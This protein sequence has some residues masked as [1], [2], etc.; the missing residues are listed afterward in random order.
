MLNVRPKTRPIARATWALALIA[1]ALLCFSACGRGERRA[2]KHV[3]LFIGDGMS[4]ES[5]IA[6]SRYLYGKD[7]ALAWHSLP[8]E[9]YEATWD[10][11][12]YNLNA[13]AAGRPRYSAA[14]FD[15]SLGYDVRREGLRPYPEARSVGA[16]RPVA[17]PAT[18]SASAATAL[19][20]GVKTDSGN[21]AWGAGDPPEAGL[22]TIAE[23][24]R[25]AR[26]G[27]F[28]V[29]STV[30]FDHATPA[31]F[32]SHNASRGHYYTGYKGYAG[33]GIADEII[34]DSKP[35]VVIGAGHPSFDNPSFNP[36]TGYISE[37]LYR[38]LQ[39]S[40]DYVLAERKPGRDG[41][42][43]LDEAAGL[44]LARGKKLFGLFGGPDG[45]FVHPV[46]E[47]HPGA[48]LFSG[49]SSEDPSLEDATLAAL[50]VLAA[51]PHG[52]FLMVEQGDIDWAN[53]D[54]DFRRMITCVAD[55]DAA[56]RAAV[57]F[58]DK[59]GDD[60]DWTNTVL[61]VTADHATGGMR[62]N[63]AMP[64]GPGALPRQIARPAASVELA[65]RPGQAGNGRRHSFV[66]PPVPAG[67]SPFFYPDGEV[68]YST[69]GHTNELVT[70]AA[71]GR[72]A[73]VFVDYLG[74]WYPGPIIDNTQVNAVM[75][76]ALGLAPR[77]R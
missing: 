64:L 20:T 27:G 8:V 43:T 49:E 60:I 1:A 50:R 13:K 5:E 71:K 54:N 70:L 59:P 18:D 55:L 15:P 46:P 12:A 24:F 56:V 57:A 77:G 67:A 9:W 41:G 73:R 65:P 22:A 37:S 63:P 14:E 32:V 62:L 40:N 28:G 11:T 4:V 47:N 16:D 72:A 10:L 26:G 33:L 44:A 29:V 21:I 38:T 51:N 7:R 76:A 17:A 30:P 58:V 2:A 36:K 25:A 19:A 68:S 66:G 31:A 42:R 34:L 23:D 48:P 75:R 52:F 69:I 6:A 39:A 45:N 61:I 74:L 35:D 3:I 53:H